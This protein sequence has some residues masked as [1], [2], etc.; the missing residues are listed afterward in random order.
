MKS[1]PTVETLHKQLEEVV[2]HFEDT[3]DSNG[4][5]KQIAYF[6][7]VLNATVT[8]P[9]TDKAKLQ[10]AIEGLQSVNEDSNTFDILDVLREA[11]NYLEM[12]KWYNAGCPDNL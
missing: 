2:E 10:N 12:L 7:D 8:H 6:R 1:T 3:Y 4:L 9:F 5:N 11:L